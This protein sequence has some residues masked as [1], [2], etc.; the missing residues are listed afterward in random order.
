MIAAETLAGQF[1]GA[2]AFCPG[3]GTEV[4]SDD[5][6]LGRRRLGLRATPGQVLSPGE[7]VAGAL[8]H[9]LALA[10]CH[11]VPAFAGLGSAGGPDPGA[12]AVQLKGQVACF[13]HY[14]VK[15]AERAI[16]VGYCLGAS[17]RPYL[18]QPEA[19]PE[20]TGCHAVQHAEAPGRADA[21]ARPA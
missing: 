21:G 18:L 12:R 8:G 20:R 17:T 7:R 5:D 4:V 13:A 16:D 15:L 6:E 10:R 3:T 14:L 1:P 9:R 19:C 11:P 2:L